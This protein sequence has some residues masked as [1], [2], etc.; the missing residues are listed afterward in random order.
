MELHTRSALGMALV[1]GAL[2]VMMAIGVAVVGIYEQSRDRR[3]APNGHRLQGVAT[4]SAIGGV[5]RDRDLGGVAH[6]WTWSGEPKTLYYEVGARYEPVELGYQWHRRRRD[7]GVPP[8]W[9]ALREL[10]PGE[11]KPNQYL[12]ETGFGWPL[13]TLLRRVV[14]KPGDSPNSSERIIE[15]GD[16]GDRWNVA[17]GRS[18]Y[19]P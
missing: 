9:S 10:P 2:G 11:S 5:L 4:G 14:I 19:E 12:I 6:G 8:R 18:I 7:K 15:S 16:I 17:I 3:I 13:A 1:Y